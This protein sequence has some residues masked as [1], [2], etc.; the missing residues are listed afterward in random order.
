MK[1]IFRVMNGAPIEAALRRLSAAGK[2]LPSFSNK[3][4]T[5]VF[6]CSLLSFSLR[7]AAQVNPD[8]EKVLT[9]RTGKIVK[10]LGITDSSRYH[11]V[12]NTIVH[13]YM[14]LNAVHEQ[15]KAAVAAIKVDSSKSDKAAAIKQEE[16][17]KNT[18]LRELHQHFVTSLSK[19]LNKEQVEQVKDGLTYRVLPVTYSA[20]QDM[21]PQLTTAQKAQ[22]YNWLIEA[23]ELAMD[24]G[25]SDDKHKVFGK[26]KGRINN[27]LST[28]GYDLKKE[29]AAWQQRLKERRDSK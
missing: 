1:K 10:T 4:V 5:V 15:Y 29:T 6:G 24:E 23:R 8:Y 13:Q 14:D 12:M 27:Y 25:S 28:A 22:I 2:Y 20:Y 18:A 3:I 7:S 19:D 9:E 17:K 26:Y 11:A 21:L 16:D